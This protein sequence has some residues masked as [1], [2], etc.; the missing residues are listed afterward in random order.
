MDKIFECH[1]HRKQE[2]LT[3]MITSVIAKRIELMKMMCGI[4]II[5]FS[6]PHFKRYLIMV[7]LIII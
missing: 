6:C 1:I 7:R 4:H 5:I 2:L 3:R